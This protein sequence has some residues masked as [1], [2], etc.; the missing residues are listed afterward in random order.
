MLTKI[1]LYHQKAV[2]LSESA[3]TEVSLRTWP[4]GFLSTFHSTIVAQKESI[5][6]GRDLEARASFRNIL[7][8]ATL[9]RRIEFSR[10]S[11][12]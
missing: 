4:D 5:H 3:R 12:A 7:I 9:L 11:A 1:R 6:S 8:A 10:T 2:F